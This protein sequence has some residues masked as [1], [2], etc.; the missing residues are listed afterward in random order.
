MT[1]SSEQDNLD[2]LLDKKINNNN[3]NTQD[4]AQKDVSGSPLPAVQPVTPSN[5]TNSNLTQLLAQL[6]NSSQNQLN[7]DPLV[8]TLPDTLVNSEIWRKIQI[9]VLK[10]GIVVAKTMNLLY[11]AK[12]NQEASILEVTKRKWYQILCRH[13][14]ANRTK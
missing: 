9:L 2:V 12:Q 1:R 6:Q 11:E 7:I 10:F 4:S 3:S 13:C 5:F 8:A 14:H